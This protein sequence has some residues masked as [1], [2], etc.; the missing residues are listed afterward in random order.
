MLID[1]DHFKFVNDRFGHLAGDDVLV[2]VAEVM[3]EQTRDYD[4]CARFG[5]DE[6]AVLLPNSDLV[7]ARRTATRILRHVD[8]IRV[9]VGSDTIQTSVSIGVAELSH[10]GEGVTDLLA[11]ADLALYRA[12]S[13]GRHQLG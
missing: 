4:S 9:V 7:E 6:F 12:K 2:K 8:E 1:L 13:A 10:R 11:A 3:R 5:G